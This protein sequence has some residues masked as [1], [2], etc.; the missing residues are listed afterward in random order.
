M[1]STR[2]MRRGQRPGFRVVARVGPTR[3]PPEREQERSLVA[4]LRRGFLDGRSIGDSI[5]AGEVV[6]LQDFKEGVVFAMLRS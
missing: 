5:E 2:A 6:L 4:A 1:T 3:V